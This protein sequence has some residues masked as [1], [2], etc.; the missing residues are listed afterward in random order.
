MGLLKLGSVPLRYTILAKLYQPHI[1]ALALQGYILEFSIFYELGKNAVFDF[2]FISFLFIPVISFIYV[3]RSNS[4]VKNKLLLI[5]VTFILF[6]PSTFQFITSKLAIREQI[7]NQTYHMINGRIR[8]HKFNIRSRNESFTVNDQKFTFQKNY[9]FAPRNFG[10]GLRE[11]DMV[12]VYYDPYSKKVL[13]MEIEVSASKRIQGE[14]H[15]M[16]S[17]FEEKYL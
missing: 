1:R 8:D 11:N 2:E 9:T 6:L 12:K 15:G 17:E 7:I 5:S 14:I 10:S 16:K 4:K 3:C 13:K